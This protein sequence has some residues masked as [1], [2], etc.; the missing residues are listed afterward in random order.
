MK[1]VNLCSPSPPCKAVCQAN[2]LSQL[3]SAGDRLNFGLAAEQAK[4]EGLK[5][6]VLLIGDDCALP[7]QGASKRRGMAGAVLI[8]KACA[9]CSLPQD[10]SRVHLVGCIQH[11]A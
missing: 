4:A 8:Y 9:L 3:C 10:D 6:E 7:Q 5:V 1:S 11:E 2:G